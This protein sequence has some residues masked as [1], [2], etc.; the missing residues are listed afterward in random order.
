MNVKAKFKSQVNP[1]TKW[2]SIHIY[3]HTHTQTL[4]HTL[5]FKDV[6]MV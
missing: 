4:D 5:I 3:T 1:S 6:K 2:T